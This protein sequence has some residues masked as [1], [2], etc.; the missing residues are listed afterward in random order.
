ME[1]AISTLELRAQRCRRAAQ[2]LSDVARFLDATGS[3]ARRARQGEEA[4]LGAAGGPGRRDGTPRQAAREQER[5]EERRTS[6]SSRASSARVVSRPA[7]HPREPG[8]RAGRAARRPRGAAPRRRPRAQTCPGQ[9]D[10][11][12]GGRLGSLVRRRGDDDG[13]DDESEGEEAPRE[14]RFRDNP[15]GSSTC[16]SSSTSS[17]TN[18]ERDLYGLGVATALSTSSGK[19][20]SD[21]ARYFGQEAKTVKRPRRQARQGNAPAPPVKFSLR[22]S[23]EEAMEDVAAVTLAND[24]VKLEGE[25]MPARRNAKRR[26]H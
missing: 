21:V 12:A 14:R 19:L 3:G 7:S 15:I 16:T 8:R 23:E 2:L 20:L 9:G 24:V 11:R 5:G 13:R 18:G 6:G 10:G 25:V 17:D 26:R 22:L 4:W 1:R